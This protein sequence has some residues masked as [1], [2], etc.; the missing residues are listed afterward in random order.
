MRILN[1][2]IL[3]LALFLIIFSVHGQDQ[4][5]KQNSMFEPFS[6]RAEVEEFLRTAEIVKEKGSPRGVTNPRR[7]TLDDGRVQHDAL[8]K[9][10]DERK[11][12]VT[13][14]GRSS[15]FD[16]K[17][18]WK[19]EVAA[20]EIDKLLSLNMVP[21]T[22]ERMYKNRTGSLQYWMDDC[23]QES[24]RI[25]KKR[26]PPS[27]VRWNWQIYKVWIFDKLIYNIDRNLGN[28]L[29]TPD[30]HAV[31]ID[32]SRSFKSINKAEA[33]EKLEF[34]S[35]SLMQALNNLDETVVKEK[36]GRWLLDSEIKTMMKRRDL[37]AEYYKNMVA[38]KGNS[39][40]YP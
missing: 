31:M 21:V 9:A 10:I 1:T 40:V 33:L 5:P 29:V 35:R 28:I 23:I 24:E 7:V 27:L 36:C 20:Y 32:H 8:F 22:V 2:P 15:E 19:F 25:E 38:E 17:D 11:P 37:I 26:Q 18:S 13:R 3:L 6:T 39:V 30:W 4:A 12:G 14:L 16:F 34:F